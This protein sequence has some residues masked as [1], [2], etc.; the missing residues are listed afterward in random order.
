MKR[1]YE[2]SLFHVQLSYSYMIKIFTVPCATSQIFNMYYIEVNIEKRKQDSR[3][4]S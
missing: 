1:E 4:N 2:N 3:G